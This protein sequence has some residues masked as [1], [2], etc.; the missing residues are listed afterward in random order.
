MET[1]LNLTFRMRWEPGFGPLD[2]KE[3]TIGA[4][5]LSCFVL[6]ITAVGVL[7]SKATL[8]D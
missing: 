8:V 5:A 6:Y 4:F 2:E 1:E 3:A 7:F